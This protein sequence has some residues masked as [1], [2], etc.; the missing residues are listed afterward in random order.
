MHLQQSRE[1]RPQTYL[2]M[3]SRRDLIDHPK[4]EI[5]DRT[6]KSQV[7]H[8]LFHGFHGFTG[9]FTGFTDSRAVRTG[10]TGFL[11]GQDTIKWATIANVMPIMIDILS[12]S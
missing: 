1:D 6:P 4:K 10:F 8:G 2:S 9:C 12:K 11:I 3:P 7:G 5:Q